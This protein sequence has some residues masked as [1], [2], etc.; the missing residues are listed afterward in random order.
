M[1]PPT[2]IAEALPQT[3]PDDF[4]EWDGASGEPSAPSGLVR[5]QTVSGVTVARSSLPKVE[6]R[7]ANPLAK[8]VQRIRT[9]VS[10]KKSHANEK[11][12][13]DQ[14]ISAGAVADQSPAFPSVIPIPPSSGALREGAHPSPSP[15]SPLPDAKVAGRPNVPSVIDELRSAF[16]YQVAVAEADEV[17]LPAIRSKSPAQKKRKPAKIEL[18]PGNH[19]R[20][21]RLIIGV[22]AAVLLLLG[23]A[24]VPLFRSHWVSGVANGERPQQAGE[25][26]AAAHIVKPSPEVPQ[27]PYQPQGSNSTQPTALVQPAASG[28][29]Q[30]DVTA[31]AQPSADDQTPARPQVQSQMM[32]EQLSSPSRISQEMKTRATDEAPPA[33]APVMSGMEGLGGNGATGSILS[34]SSLPG[35]KVAPPRVIAVSAATAVGMLLKNPPP[36]Y[37]QIARSAGVSGTVVIA[38]TISK[39]GTVENL[40]VISGPELLRQAALNAVRTWKYR[41]YLI[42]NQPTS[43]ETTINVVFKLS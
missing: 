29:A 5:V 42:D 1:A 7:P 32:N 40:H 15:H 35:V 39:T 38:A 8:E 19:P 20:N 26:S 6:D 4:G 12:F 24:A 10:G 33:G 14:L 34:G 23:A 22:S 3:L 25:P 27:S 13:L 2:Q 11:A 21:R 31:N 36:A 30:A 16:A 28:N 18:A 37:P 43:V 41:P 17:L 9:A